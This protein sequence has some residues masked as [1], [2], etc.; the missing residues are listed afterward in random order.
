V[1]IYNKAQLEEIANIKLPDLNTTKVSSAMKIVEGPYAIWYIHCRLSLNYMVLMEKSYAKTIA[2]SYRNLKK[3]KSA[4]YSNLE[5]AIVALKETAT[6][7]FV[8]CRA[9]CEFK[10]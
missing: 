5:E 1:W 2:S 10:Y 9:T 7:K 6:T 8:E 4:L 3:T